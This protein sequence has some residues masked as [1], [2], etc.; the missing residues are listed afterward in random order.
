M[1]VLYPNRRPKEK[2]DY[3]DMAKIF[4]DKNGEQ[5]N[6]KDTPLQCRKKIVNDPVQATREEALIQQIQAILKVL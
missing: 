4:C 5:I 3:G 6:L 1:E 2:P